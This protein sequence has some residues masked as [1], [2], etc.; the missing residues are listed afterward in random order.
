MTLNDCLTGTLAPY[1]PSAQQPWDRRRAAH[2]YRRLGLG[3]APAVLDAALQKSP[4]SLVDQLISQ[5]LTAP[6]QPAPVWANWTLDDYPNTDIAIEQIQIWRE[7]WAKSMLVTGLRERMALFWHNHFVTKITTYNCPSWMFRYHRLLQQHAL[8][9]FKDMTIA[10]GKTPAMLVY[11]N[12]VQSTRVQPNENYARELYE[13]FTLGRDN[14]YT[15]NDIKE[16]ARALT[17]WNQVTVLCGDINFLNLGFDPGS[18]TIFGQTGNWGYD[19]VHRILFEQRSNQIAENICR[20]IYRHF[21]SPDVPEEIVQ[22]L[23]ATFKANNFAIAP[24]LRQ[25]F[26]SEHFFEDSVIGVQ[27][28]SP[29]ELFLG[30]LKDGDFS[31]QREDLWR[32][33]VF[34]SGELGQQLLDPVDVAGWPGNRQWVNSNSLTGR[35]NA[36]RLL[37]YTIYQEQPEQY[38]QLAKSLAGT[39]ISDADLI[40]RAIADHF[41]PMGLQSEEEY[42]RAALVFKGQIPANYFEDGSWSLEWDIAPAQ[43]ALLIDHLIRKPEFQLI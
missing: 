15:Q 32:A 19:D 41:I 43:V 25:L 28:K 13:L 36:L 5:A 24:V 38:R 2:L 17:G 6:L 3:A 9:N 23:A 40:S 14:G 30:L 4:G 21:V 7:D 10:M 22:G 33:L 35:W 16:T 12:G 34:I 8:G 31:L 11:L 42:S 20:K 18:K 37:I 27:V 1:Q 39:R 29:L 26:K